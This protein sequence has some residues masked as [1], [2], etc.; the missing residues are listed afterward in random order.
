MNASDS[1]LALAKTLTDIRVVIVTSHPARFSARVMYLLHSERF[2]SNLKTP[3]QK[4]S[5]SD[6]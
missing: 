2:S 6:T 1:A 5:R 3:P 4:G